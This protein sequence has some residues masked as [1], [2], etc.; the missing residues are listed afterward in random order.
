MFW[1]IYVIVAVIIALMFIPWKKMKTVSA[2][3]RK[4]YVLGAVIA[5][6]I[7]LIPII[8]VI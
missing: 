3:E 1:Y 2:Q 5:F 8:G 6:G 4:K 7:F